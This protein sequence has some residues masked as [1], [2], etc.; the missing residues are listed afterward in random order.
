MVPVCRKGLLT[1]AAL[2]RAALPFLAAPRALEPASALV[3][4]VTKAAFLRSL[5]SQGAH[6]LC[7]YVCL[8]GAQ[9][10]LV[11]FKIVATVAPYKMWDCPENWYCLNVRYCPVLLSD[12]GALRA[13]ICQGESGSQLGRILCLLLMF[14]EARCL[15]QFASRTFCSRPWLNGREPPAE[16]RVLH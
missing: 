9:T 7:S 10:D 12:H 3:S 14:Y 6:F 13:C 15:R 16:E 11:E 1:C 4:Q 5:V 8:P 2:S